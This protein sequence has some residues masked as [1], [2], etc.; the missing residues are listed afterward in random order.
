MGWLGTPFMAHS[1]ELKKGRATC[2]RCAHAAHDRERALYVCRR[3]CARRV[4]GSRGAG[5]TS[6]CAQQC[7]TGFHT[8]L[9][10][11]CAVPCFVHGRRKHSTLVVAEAVTARTMGTRARA[12]RR[13]PPPGDSRRL[14]RVASLLGMCSL[15]YASVEWSSGLYSSQLYSKRLSVRNRVLGLARLDFLSGL[16]N[17]AIACLDFLS[18]LRNRAI[19]SSPPAAAL[20]IKA[21]GGV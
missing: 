11:A 13:S 2:E 20:E 5:V 14:S 18:G 17:R 21:P 9:V 6:A 12:L 4:W 15:R 19:F 1:S 3:G 7:A 16:R 10:H 8:A